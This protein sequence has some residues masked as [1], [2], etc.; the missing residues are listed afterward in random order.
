MKLIS[1]NP[2]AYPA[3]SLVLAGALSSAS[4]QIPWAT[5]LF[6]RQNKTEVYALGEYLHQG[7]STFPGPLGGSPAL[8]LDD[9]GLGGAGF[10]FHFS[11][12]FS[13]HT[14]FMLGPATLRTQ[15]S[16]G[17]SSTFGHNA[18]IQSGRFN[19]DYNIINR[20]L[21]PFITAG[22]GYQYLQVEQDTPDFGDFYHDHHYSQANFTWNAGAGIRWNITD[23]FFI[24]VTG[25]AQWLEYHD[26]N[27]VLT[28]IEGSLA[29][30]CTL[31]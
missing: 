29:I 18:F 24:K 1:L 3:A 15:D 30:G 9:T 16:A 23:N 22:I 17:G 14:D 19:L 2:L 13:F 31:P 4:A 12:F 7:N 6:S 11:D 27:N 21:T 28:Q 5:D 20:R 26:A 10:A 8:T 25:G